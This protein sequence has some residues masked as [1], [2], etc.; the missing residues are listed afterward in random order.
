MKLHN[1]FVLLLTAVLF[2]CGGKAEQEVEETSTEDILAEIESEETSMK[3]GKYMLGD[4][5]KLMWEGSKAAGTH[6]GTI[7]ISSGSFEVSNGAL[8]AGEF[9]V[10]MTS[11]VN[12]DLG[13]QETKDKLVGHLQSPDFFNVEEY[14]Q[15]TFKVKNVEA[16]TEEGATHKITGDLTIKGITN[17]ISFP[18]TVSQEGDAISTV[19]SFNIDRTRWEVKFRSPQFPEFANIA[20]D[21]IISDEIKIE[22][23]LTGSMA[24]A[25]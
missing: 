15:A 7:G 4:D 11:I 17:E 12:N 6:N 10:D 20:A 3:D 8:S 22:F 13:D 1:L 14:N 21:K 9:T 25:E 19:A 23:S 24:A 18:A 5:A 16:S 2:A